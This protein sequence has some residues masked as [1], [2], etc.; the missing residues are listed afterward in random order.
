MFIIYGWGKKTVK[1]YGSTL[2]I[3]C[4]NCNNDGHLNLVRV[5]FGK[6]FSSFQSYHTKQIFILFATLV[7]L[8]QTCMEKI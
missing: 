8:V 2:Q 7:P 1:N 4:G 5:R 6:L 3:N